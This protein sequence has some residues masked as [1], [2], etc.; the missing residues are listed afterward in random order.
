MVCIRFAS[1]FSLD[2]GRKWISGEEIQWLFKSI[3]S[4][5]KYALM[6]QLEMPVR[7]LPHHETM[8]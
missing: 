5:E 7:I 8:Y 1:I 6:C 3:I 4:Q 2:S